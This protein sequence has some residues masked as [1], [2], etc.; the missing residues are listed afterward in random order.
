MENTGEFNFDIEGNYIKQ[1]Y[2]ENG[3]VSDI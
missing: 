2:F 1:R 3:V